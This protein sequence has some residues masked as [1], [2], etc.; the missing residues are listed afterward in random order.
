MT[1]SG[2]KDLF[3]A[4]GRMVVLVVDTDAVVELADPLRRELALG[5]REDRAGA[6]HQTPCGIDQAIYRLDGVAGGVEA[7]E[8]CVRLLVDLGEDGVDQ[9]GFVAAAVVAAVA[10][11]VAVVLVPSVHGSAQA[12]GHGHGH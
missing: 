6:V 3:S 8:R 4:L 10:A 2:K 7:L 5:R 1:R 11:G 9:L 12:Q